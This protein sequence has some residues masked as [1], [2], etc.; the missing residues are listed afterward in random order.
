[1]THLD[2][3][4]AP[5][6]EAIDRPD[7]QALHLLDDPEVAALIAEVDA[8]LC[9][10]LTPVRCSPAPPVTGCA[11]LGPRSAGRSCGAL[12]PAW[13]GPAHRVRAVQRGPPT[14]NNPRPRSTTTPGSQVMASQQI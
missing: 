7:Q 9:A 14:D 13:E 1:M 12:V 4:V 11:L 5:A 2:T 8:I 3:V 10:A 6:S